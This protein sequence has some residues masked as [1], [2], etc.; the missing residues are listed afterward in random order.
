[1]SGVRHGVLQTLHYRRIA[2]VNSSNRKLQDLMSSSHSFGFWQK[3]LC[4]IWELAVCPHILPILISF[5]MKLELAKTYGNKLAKLRRRV[6]RVSLGSKKLKKNCWPHHV[7]TSL[8]SWLPWRFDPHRPV[9]WNFS[10]LLTTSKGGT[11]SFL[12][13]I[14]FHSAPYPSDTVLSLNILICFH[15][16]R[17][18]IL[19]W[20]N[21][22]SHSELY[23]PD[24]IGKLEQGAS[25]TLHN[26][27]YILS[28]S[29]ADQG[30]HP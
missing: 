7:T 27:E 12:F 4:H 8:E 23:S 30:S 5:L 17:S 25:C 11:A 13:P 10:S 15:L 20:S 24:L 9:L 3:T 1:M 14:S 16:F 18:S 21:M 19:S 26:Q 29:D 22:H 6:S 28:E 2:L